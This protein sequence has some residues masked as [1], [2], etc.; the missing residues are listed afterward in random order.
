MPIPDH[1]LPD[2]YLKEIGRVAVEWSRLEAAVEVAIWTLLFSR[3]TERPA[4]FDEEIGRAVTTNIAVLLRIDMLVTIA[5]VRIA[6]AP[7]YFEPLTAIA[8]RVR[9]AYPKRN[10][11]IHAIWE[12]VPR[13]AFRQTYRAR[14]TLVASFEVISLA[15]IGAT[16]SEIATLT[17]DLQAFIADISDLYVDR[18]PRRLEQDPQDRA[19]LT[20]PGRTK[21]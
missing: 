8:A 4:W 5:R 12:A 9:T 14:G 10:R 20:P 15:E 7:Q 18:I 6:A 13:G 16:A 21:R 3:E 11:I 19:Y 17:N 1:N 2:D